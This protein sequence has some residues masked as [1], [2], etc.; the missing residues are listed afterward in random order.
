MRDPVHISETLRS[1]EARRVETVREAQGLATAARMTQSSSRGQTQ[2][3]G[4][5]RRLEMG[6]K[7]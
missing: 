3:N 1:F 7:K 6:A 2:S 4:P 5:R